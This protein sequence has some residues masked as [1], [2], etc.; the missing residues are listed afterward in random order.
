MD[1]EFPVKVRE[2]KVRHKSGVTYVERRQYR[3]DPKLGHNVVLKSERIGKIDPGTNQI[4]PCRPRRKKSEPKPVAEP[5]ATENSSATRVSENLALS[6][7]ITTVER[8]QV[9]EIL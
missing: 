2:V 1:A 3:Y 4:V 5:V 6:L 9:V 8:K 7:G